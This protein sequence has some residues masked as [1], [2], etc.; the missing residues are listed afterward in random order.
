MGNDKK[1][2]HPAWLSNPTDLKSCHPSYVVII[3]NSF[4]I[5]LSLLWL[6]PSTASKFR[7]STWNFFRLA[8]DPIYFF[9]YLCIYFLDKGKNYV[10]FRITITVLLYCY[11]NITVLPPHNIIFFGYFMSH[12]V[13]K[14]TPPST[15]AYLRPPTTFS[16]GMFIALQ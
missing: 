7:S 12:G 1:L 11:Y 13:S 3:P 4:N 10:S 8:S 15:S 2:T 14:K 6:S 16:P 5:L 9:T